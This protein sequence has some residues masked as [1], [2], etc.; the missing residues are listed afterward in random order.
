MK[1]NGV[2]DLIILSN[3]RFGNWVL[4]K[5]NIPIIKQLLWLIYKIWYKLVIETVLGS[6]VPAE[7]K[8]GKKFLK[9]NMVVM[10]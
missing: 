5:F 2:R 7:A 9:L 3:Y 6:E 4:Y 1:Y 10:G 8:I